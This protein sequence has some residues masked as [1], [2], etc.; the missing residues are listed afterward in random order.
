L[1]VEKEPL[2][3][4]EAPVTSVPPAEPSNAIAGLLVPPEPV[5]EVKVYPLFGVANIWTLVPASYQPVSPEIV[6]L[7]V[8]TEVPPPEGELTK[9]SWCCV[10]EL[11]LI[12]WAAVMAI[13][14]V[15][16]VPVVATFVLEPPSRFHDAIL[17]PVPDERP[18]TPFDDTVKESPY[19]YQP[20]EV[21]EERE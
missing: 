18:Q 16:T 2:V 14:E 5:Q 3:T 6:G 21:S 20:S 10:T 11:K 12:V 9:V 1:E 8:A 7:V 4:L 19:L 13:G 17:V 15:V